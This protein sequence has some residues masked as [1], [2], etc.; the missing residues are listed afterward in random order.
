[1]ITLTTHNTEHIPLLYLHINSIS[2]RSTCYT[3]S[4]KDENISHFSNFLMIGLCD[5]SANC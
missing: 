1:M 5:S 3:T 4:I 2:A